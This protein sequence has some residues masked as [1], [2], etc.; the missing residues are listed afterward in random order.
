M[1]QDWTVTGW[2]EGNTTFSLWSERDRAHAHLMDTD[3]N[4]ILSIWD[5]AVNELIEDGFIKSQPNMHT[6]MADY[7]NH[8]DL[9]VAN[10]REINYEEDKDVQDM[11]DFAEEWVD[12]TETCGCLVAVRLDVDISEHEDTKTAIIAALR[13]LLEED[14]DAITYTVEDSAPHY[15]EPGLPTWH[16]TEDANDVDLETNYEDDLENGGLDA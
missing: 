8:L 13:K 1:K 11:S 9:S 15:N 5:N 10:P 6:S 4:T 12:E 3:G 7:A 16:T 2:T 14:A